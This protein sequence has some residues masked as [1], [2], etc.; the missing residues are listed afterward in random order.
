MYGNSAVFTGEQVG[1]M[2]SLNLYEAYTDVEKAIDLAFDGHFV[3]KFYDYLKIKKVKKVEIEE[4][5]QSSTAR[6]LSD[7]VLE[8]NDYLEGGSDSMHKQLREG[9]GHIPKPQARKIKNYLNKILEDALRYNHD[10]RR[11]RRKKETK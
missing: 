11:G 2:S 6:E 4:F 7:L 3:L 1:L 8:L 5:I 9:Y 10:R